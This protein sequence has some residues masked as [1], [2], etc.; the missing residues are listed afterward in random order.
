MPTNIMQLEP[1]H[2]RWPVWGDQ[3]NPK[4]DPKA[5]PEVALFCAAP[6][7]DKRY[8]AAHAAAARDAYQPALRLAPARD[9]STRKAAPEPV[10]PDAFDLLRDDAA[11]IAAEPH[12]RAHTHEGVFA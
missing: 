9:A 10:E 5:K 8:C 6:K 7:A 1:H 11:V 4:R 2:C 3:R 12:V